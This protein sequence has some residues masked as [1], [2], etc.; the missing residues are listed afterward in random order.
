AADALGRRNV[1]R[2]MAGAADIRF[3]SF[4]ERLEGADFVAFVVNL[5]VGRAHQFAEFIIKPLGAEITFFFRYPFVQTEMRLDDEIC[6][7]FLSLVSAGV[8]VTVAPRL[9]AFGDTPG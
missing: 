2:P 4:F 7:C 5:T 3:A 6:H 1:H 8:E 9:S